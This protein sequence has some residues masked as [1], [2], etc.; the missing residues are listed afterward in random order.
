MTESSFLTTRGLLPFS[1]QTGANGGG[2]F[3]SVRE[4]VI[5]GLLSCGVDNRGPWGA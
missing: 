1:M 3:V 2:I 5:L 4:D